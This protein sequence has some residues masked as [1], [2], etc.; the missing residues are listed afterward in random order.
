V[1]QSSRLIRQRV[2]SIL[3]VQSHTVV[4]PGLDRPFQA[5]PLD[6]TTGAGFL[7]RRFDGTRLAGRG[8][9]CFRSALLTPLTRM[10]MAAVE[11]MGKNNLGSTHHGSGAASV[12]E[13]EAARR[14]FKPAR[15]LP[16]PVWSE[17][18]AAMRSR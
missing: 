16:A 3:M 14:M 11:P 1:D 9:S 18:K 2:A 13:G 5:C 12:P 17:P 8:S 15:H 6:G 4:D 7:R 10:G